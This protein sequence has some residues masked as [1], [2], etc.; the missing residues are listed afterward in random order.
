MTKYGIVVEYLTGEIEHD[1]SAP[2]IYF[3]VLQRECATYPYLL[4]VY[5][6][7]TSVYYGFP[8]GHP[9]KYLEVSNWVAY[10]S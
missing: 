1:S 4:S 8:T 10:I 9:V 2:N 5:A 7:A 6:S 3:M